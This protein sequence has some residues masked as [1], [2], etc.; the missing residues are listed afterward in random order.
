MQDLSAMRAHHSLVF[1]ALLATAACASETPAPSTSEAAKG[2]ELPPSATGKPKTPATPDD[3]AP[4]PATCTGSPGEVYE[5]SLKK[6]A[7]VDELKLCTLKGS[8]MLVVNGASGCGYT[9]QYAPLQTLYAKYH[10]TQK[11]KFEVLAFPSKS[12]NQEKDTD[13]DVS[14][15]C[16]NEY[17]I[18][19]P[20][21]T[22]APVIDD[23]AK[24]VTAQPI[25]KWIY[26]QPGMDKPVTWNFEK[27]LIS[28]DGKVAKRFPTALSP[29]EGGEID[30]A[31]AAELAK[32]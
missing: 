13:A 3:P 23:A 1:V 12:F 24:G 8:V 31:I 27:F 14:A 4:A 20:L 32:P 10:D 2:G 29:D 22:I 7:E 9:P 6:L 19:F 16:T 17:H 26:A 5:L 25:Y 30:L 21:F 11:A 15:F 18:T 28:K